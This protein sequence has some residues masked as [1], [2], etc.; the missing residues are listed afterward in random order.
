MLFVNELSFSYGAVRALEDI[1]LHAPGGQ[2][3]CV[4][5]RNG[6]GKT[7]LM[8]N[9]M[10]SLR[11][12][13]GSVWLNGQ[14]VTALPSNKRARQGLALVPQGRQIFPKLTVEENL[15][16][17]LEARADGKKVIPEEIYET[18]PVL[19]TMARRMGGDLL[20]LALCADGDRGQ[21]RPT[22]IR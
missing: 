9:I 6:V 17:G 16:V 3:T 12:S 10:G 15:R 21:V 11:C 20:R 22:R 5:G 4:M 2:I 18:F 13:A 1:N 7:T 19:K 8:K 14:D